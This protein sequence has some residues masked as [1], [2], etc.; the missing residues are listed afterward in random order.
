[1]DYQKRQASI[2]DE[3]RARKTSAGKDLEDAQRDIRK[4]SAESLAEHNTVRVEILVPA[5]MSSSDG[6]K[7]KTLTIRGFVTDYEVAREPLEVG[8]R[9]HISKVTLKA[10]AVGPPSKGDR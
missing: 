3:Y 7:R 10:T 1:M 8:G 5:E 9:M 6:S 4:R 2:V